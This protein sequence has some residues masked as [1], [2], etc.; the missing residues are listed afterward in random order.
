VNDESDEP[1]E[2]DEPH[3]ASG[4]EARVAILAQGGLEHVRELREVLRV[5]GIEAHVVRPPEGAGSS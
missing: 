3:E 4:E 5:R 2:L 1:E